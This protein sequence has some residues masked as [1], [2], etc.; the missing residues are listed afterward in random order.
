MPS[1]LQQRKA[2]LAACAAK[3]AIGTTPAPDGRLAITGLRAYPLREPVSGRTY[4]VIKIET[5]SGLA[6]YGETIGI[7]PLELRQAGEAIR[8]REATEIEDLRARLSSMP[9]VRAAVNMALLDIVG[10]FTKAPVYQVLG[11]PTRN[12]A[13]VL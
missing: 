6:G 11:G 7:S 1:T 2:R 9:R 3:A 12:K 4:T 10:K 8:A 13:R 5:S